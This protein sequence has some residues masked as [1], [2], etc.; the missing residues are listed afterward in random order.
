[1]LR[2]SSIEVNCATAT[3]DTRF[4]KSRTTLEMSLQISMALLLVYSPSS[5]MMDSNTFTLIAMP[6]ATAYTSVLGMSLVL[7][8]FTLALFV[9]VCFS[10]GFLLVM[11]IVNTLCL[12]LAFNLTTLVV[13]KFLTSNGVKTMLASCNEL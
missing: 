1:M 8:S 9:P 12:L 10:F 4:A 2:Y 13:L 3:G 6:L 7:L 11:S 5:S